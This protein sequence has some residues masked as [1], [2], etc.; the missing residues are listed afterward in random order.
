VASPG[1]MVRRLGVDI[2]EME[3]FRARAMEIFRKSR[4]PKRC[5]RL[6]RI[7][8]DSILGLGEFSGRRA[9]SLPEAHPPLQGAMVAIEEG[10]QSTKSLADAGLVEADATPLLLVEAPPA[11]PV[12]DAPG[13]Q[14]GKT[15]LVRP[16]SVGAELQVDLGLTDDPVD[17]VSDFRGLVQVCITAG[18][19]ISQIKT[20]GL[21]MNYPEEVRAMKI[22]HLCFAHGVPVEEE[23][24]PGGLWVFGKFLVQQKG[25]SQTLALLG[26]GLKLQLA[27]GMF[28]CNRLQMMKTQFETNEQDQLAGK[29]TDNRRKESSVPG[30]KIPEDRKQGGFYKH[31]R[32]GDGKVVDFSYVTDTMDVATAALSAGSLGGRRRAQ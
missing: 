29:Q 16:A 3:S 21:N 25:Q 18:R 20:T 11:A 10:V 6:M 4:N 13:R 17:F 19:G 24:D 31:V 14:Y 32:T 9:C 5:L 1:K 2:G 22:A 15:S 8:A 27:K 30:E 28:E 26:L 12:V 23:P 7:K